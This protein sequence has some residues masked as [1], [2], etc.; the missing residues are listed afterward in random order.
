[1]PN[2]CNLFFF[3][4]VRYESCLFVNHKKGGWPRFPHFSSFCADPV[5]SWKSVLW[6]SLVK[7]TQKKWVQKTCQWQMLRCFLAPNNFSPTF[8]PLSPRPRPTNTVNSMTIHNKFELT[9]ASSWWLP[10]RACNCIWPQ[11]HDSALNHH[12]QPLHST[13]MQRRYPMQKPGA[14]TLCTCESVFSTTNVQ[15]LWRHSYT[16]CCFLG[17]VPAEWPPR[18]G[19]LLLLRQN[20]CWE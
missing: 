2:L 20:P 5:T 1:M 19:D 3:N 14:T 17:R 10:V 18:E 4:T 12:H 6:L 16:Y 7:L 13:A 8:L 9:A 15:Y 11:A